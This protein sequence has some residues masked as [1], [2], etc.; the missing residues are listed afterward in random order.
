MRR[1]HCGEIGHQA[2]EFLARV[3]INVAG[4]GS[5]NTC[6]LSWVTSDYTKTVYT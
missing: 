4:P 6:M 1:V 5:V 2:N 3:H